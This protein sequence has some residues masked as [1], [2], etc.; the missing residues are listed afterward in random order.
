MM[1]GFDWPVVLDMNILEIGGRPRPK[2]RR[3]LGDAHTFSLP[4][5]HYGSGELESH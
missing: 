4:W 3:T 1:F 5:E 2:D